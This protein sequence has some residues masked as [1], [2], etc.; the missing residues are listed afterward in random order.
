MPLL[1]HFHPARRSN[2][3]A[4]A[5]GSVAGRLLRPIRGETPPSGAG[6]AAADGSDRAGAYATSIGST[7]SRERGTRE[8]PTPVS[9]YDGRSTP[10]KHNAYALAGLPTESRNVGLTAS[11]RSV[12]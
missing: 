9:A 12:S 8:D 6:R 10:V 4:A 7:R 5:A 11:K 3:G 2:L 1:D